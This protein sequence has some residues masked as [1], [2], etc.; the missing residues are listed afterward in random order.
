VVASVTLHSLVEAMTLFA[1]V[2]PHFAEH[3]YQALKRSFPKAV[4]LFTAESVH[5]RP[6]PKVDPRWTDPQLEADMALAQDAISAVLAARDKCN[7]AVKWPVQDVRLTFTT[8]VNTATLVR[9]QELIMRRT[10]TR[11]LSFEP[12]E[13]LVTLRP[14][15]AVVGKQFG[16][17]AKAVSAFITENQ[18]QLLDVLGLPS[19]SK[20]FTL[21][22]GSTVELGANHFQVLR[23]APPSFEKA[24]TGCVQAFLDKTRTPELDEEGYLREVVRRVQMLRKKVGLHRK[25]RI[26]LYVGTTSAQVATAVSNGTKLFQDRTGV[27]SLNVGS[28]TVR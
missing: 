11:K 25:D 15:S 4:S 26:N 12:P 24:T 22:D 1:P 3:V 10:N 18:A 6:W 8:S 7:L 21:P 13:S 2:V 16:R 28:N 5:L 20:S 23:S 27:V 19:Q 9:C 14:N 17:A